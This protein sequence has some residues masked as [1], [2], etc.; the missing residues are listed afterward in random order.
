MNYDVQLIKDFEGFRSEVYECPGGHPTI[1]Y[2]HQLEKG[3]VFDTITERDAEKLMEEDLA[4]ARD[5]VS[6][7]TE[8]HALKTWEFQAITSLV[9]NVGMG[10]ITTKC[11]KFYRALRDGDKQEMVKQMRDIRMSAG[12]VMIGLETRRLSEISVFTWGGSPGK[13]VLWASPNKEKRT[14]A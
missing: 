4:Y 11:P 5:F 13:Y 12:K 8:K 14:G 1:G 10:T 2:G 3:E 7:A 6:R 9:Y